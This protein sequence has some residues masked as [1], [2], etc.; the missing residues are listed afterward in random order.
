MELHALVVGEQGIQ[1]PYKSGAMRHVATVERSTEGCC[2]RDFRRALYGFVKLSGFEGSMEIFHVPHIGRSRSAFRSADSTIARSVRIA[3]S[4]LTK[5]YRGDYSGHI[6]RDQ[7]DL[8]PREDLAARDREAHGPVPKHC[9]AACVRR[10]PSSRSVQS[11]VSP[12]VID[13]RGR[14]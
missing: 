3:C 8:V 9:T 7:A 1:T 14:C 11:C 6:G 5:R 2:D 10:V 13:D 12:S 4:S